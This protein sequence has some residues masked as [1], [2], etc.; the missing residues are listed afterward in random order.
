M[1]HPYPLP[2]TY[3]GESPPQL[4]SLR[5]EEPVASVVMAT[6]EAAWLLTRHDDVHAVLGDA[7]FRARFPGAQISA[8]DVGGLADSTDILLMQDGPEHTRVRGLVT[9]GFSAR[10]VEH[11]RTRIETCAEKMVDEL[12]RNGAPA[13]F[14]DIFAVPFVS[15][16][17]SDLLNVR[18][19]DREEFH[20]WAKAVMASAA[21][22]DYEHED[23]ADAI[24][25]LL[26]FVSKLLTDKREHP[27]DDLFSHL[28]AIYDEHDGRL[29]EG[30]LLGLGV[31]LMI[32]GF[33]PTVSVLAGGMFLLLRD[34]QLYESVRDDPGLVPAAVDEMLRFQSTDG[35]PM[36]VAKE[37]VT[38]RG[39]TIRAGE[40]VILSRAAAHRDPQ[41]FDDPDTFRLDR[42]SNP[43][44]AFGHGPHYCLGAGLA[45]LEL[46]TALNCLV[47]RLP[48]L[49]LAVPAQEV[50]W[51]SGVF[52]EM[53]RLLPVAW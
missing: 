1:P 5:E 46:E 22:S 9:R 48:H 42:K 18:V 25:N 44:V 32:A 19:E 45:R 20:H 27:A 52:F 23:V 24:L 33:L 37:D 2:S 8:D 36:R 49:T 4:T 26:V 7:R 41:V 12:I 39:A 16:V 38:I 53:P 35:D 14:A 6:G 10:Y 50:K 21:S 3:P 28:I 51:F 11:M 15:Q 40:I 13:N 47:R 17:T 29:T 34:A 43:H 31:T 30:Q